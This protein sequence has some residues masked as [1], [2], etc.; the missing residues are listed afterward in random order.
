MSQDLN[1][2]SGS[3]HTHFESIYDTGNDLGNMLDEF[4]KLGCK[5]V[6]VTDHG[7]ASAYEDLLYII[8]EKKKKNPDY[9]LDIVFGIEGYLDDGN[10]HIILLAK[11]AEGYK[12]LCNVIAE[13]EQN[14]QKNKPIITWDNLQR[15][16]A[17]GH[18]YCTTACISGSFGRLFG[19]DEYKTN[20]KIAEIEE[21]LNSSQNKAEIM[22]LEI[23]LSELQNRL[24]EIKARNV[25]AL[26][27][28]EFDKYI[29]VFGKGN[30]LFEIQNHF[31]DKE[32]VIYNRLIDFAFKK[33]YPCFVASNDIHIG[34]RNDNPDFQ[35]AMLRRNVEQFNRF[36]KYSDYSDDD[37]EY[38]IKTDAELKEALMQLDTG[39][40]YGDKHY[41]L[42]QIVDKS[43]ENI[44]KLLN[45]CTF[46]LSD[47][48]YY[49]KFCDNE[50]ELF[51]QKVWEGA[52]ERFPEGLPK[53]YEDRLNYEIGIITQMGY[54]GYHLIVADYLEYGRLLGYLPEDEIE[55]APLT[56]E[57]LDAYITQKGYPRIGYSIGPGRGSGV[58]SLCC[59]CLKI[60]DINPMEYG[61]LFERFL[62]PE[63][64]S[65]PDIDSDFMTTIRAKCADYVSHRFGEDCVCKIMTKAY[66][67]IKGNIRL[68]GRYIGT[69]EAQKCG[70]SPTKI[71]EYLKENGY[72]KASDRLAK[73]ET[74]N[75]HVCLEDCETDLEREIFEIATSIDGIF[76]Q[77]GQHAAGVVISGA[78]IKDVIPLMHQTKKEEELSEEQESSD[79]IDETP[80]AEDWLQTQCQMAQAEA[81]GLLK[82]DFL[83]LRNLNILTNIAKLM[84]KDG[85]LT[86][87]N[88]ILQNKEARLK[89]LNDP[90]VFKLFCKGLTTGVF[91]FESDGMRAMLKDFEPETFA[92][93]ILL[94]SAY[95]P[96]PM[97]FIPEIVAEKKYRKGL[98]TEKPQHSITVSNPDL[99]KILEPTYGCPIYQEQIMQIFQTQAGYTLGGAD[100]VRRYMSKKKKDKLEEERHNFIYGNKDIIENE[101][102][103][104]KQ[105]KAEFGED[106]KEAKEAKERIPSYEIFGCVKKQGMTPEEADALFDQLMPFAEYGFN[107]SHATA[108]SMISFFT[109]YYKCHYPLYFYT[110]SLNYAQA[111]GKKSITQIINSFICEMSERGI[112]YLPP[113]IQNG[114]TPCSIED[115]S[116]RIGSYL[117]K[118]FGKDDEKLPDSVE[119]L[120]RMGKSETYISSLLA[121]GF[122][123][124][125]WSQEYLVDAE[126]NLIKNED[127]EGKRSKM[128]H[129]YKELAKQ[130]DKA[131]GKNGYDKKVAEALEKVENI[132]N[133]GFTEDSKEYQKALK[134]YTDYQKKEKASLD[135]LNE[136]K[137]ALKSET[138]YEIDEDVLDIRKKEYEKMGMVFYKVEDSVSVLKNADNKNLQALR[139]SNST[140]ILSVPASILNISDKKTDK[141]GGDYYEITF[142]LADHTQTVKRYAFIP[143][144]LTGNFWMYPD[145]FIYKTVKTKGKPIK[146]EQFREE[147]STLESIEEFIDSMR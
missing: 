70:V 60:T 76:T 53:E 38:C 107:K 59:Y 12:S 21:K 31:L 116:V 51:I 35:K 34:M 132:I 138:F 120:V 105:I 66:G 57:E 103:R 143:D 33:N 97:A 65:M 22:K 137:E 62:N 39:K 41:I 72:Y 6:A 106:S 10:S 86:E 115:D 48:K 26:A 87:D 133:S 46:E 14:F 50:K 77:Y 128:I 16:I 55:N 96:G 89:A 92:D 126:G 40:T 114:I 74:E 29:S 100:T 58:G 32:K 61:L 20:D 64:V 124:R 4:E 113:T 49:P 121:L 90:E 67:A 63:R 73:L 119:E 45:A 36:G 5:K 68:A 23:K 104:Y 75:H 56:I 135:L 136:L 30:F 142:V 17:K 18:V 54:S 125:M 129:D 8:H 141:Y 139:E 130:M 2:L 7:T 3:I 147:P 71:K 98:S 81:K 85:I 47:E 42:E 101:T 79:E 88:N 93:L 28:E 110:T 127:Y 24:E 131:F 9:D 99:D 122:V 112:K 13:S 109:A 44:S 78:P 11:D 80:F 25:N 134:S 69:R 15:H 146:S 82:M 145:K 102:A 27:D 1:K 94:V 43:I 95:R 91:Q 83:G 117:V 118:G 144:Y 123:P 140:S 111:Q 37:K 52:K 84:Y 108:Y 19:M